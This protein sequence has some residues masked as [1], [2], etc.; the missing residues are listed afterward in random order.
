MLPFIAAAGLWPGRSKADLIRYLAFTSTDTL[1]FACSP[2]AV[3]TSIGALAFWAAIYF[4]YFRPK[5]RRLALT[6]G[7]YAEEKGETF[8]EDEETPLLAAESSA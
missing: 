7:E 3:G 1:V 2:S 4:C 5:F 8:S 6:G